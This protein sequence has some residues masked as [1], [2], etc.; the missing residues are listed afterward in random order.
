MKKTYLSLILIILVIGAGILLWQKYH[1]TETV[2]HLTSVKVAP[3]ATVNIP[4]YI[5]AI[6]KISAHKGKNAVITYHLPAESQAT[7]K[8]TQ[9]VHIYKSTQIEHNFIGNV[10]TISAINKSTNTI[11]LTAI[12]PDPKNTI[13]SGEIFN[14]KQ[15]I[16]MLN[17]QYLVPQDAIIPGKT[18]A[19]IFIVKDGRAIKRPIKLGQ[20]FHDFIAIHGDIAA[21][22]SV[23]ISKHA[24]IRDG[25]QVRIIQ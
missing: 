16:G 6:G 3:I 12:I 17:N 18:T 14:I 20:H 19:S 9:P 13:Q 7:V 10:A 25:Q 5:G 24:P 22:D 15:Q 11:V 23:I 8:I 21:Q 2:T 1:Q 4:N